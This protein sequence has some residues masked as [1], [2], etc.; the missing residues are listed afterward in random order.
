MP[1]FLAF[2]T[3]SDNTIEAETVVTQEDIAEKILL[4]NFGLACPLNT[5]EEV[6]E[7]ATAI[8]MSKLKFSDSTGEGMSHGVSEE[9]STATQESSDI[10]GQD[11]PVKLPLF[12]QEFVKT[13]VPVLRALHMEEDRQYAV[14]DGKIIFSG[15][16]E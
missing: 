7:R 11:V 1:E 9:R 2:M 15:F 5:Y 12:L 10:T 13:Q 4:L 6:V 3:N 16:S 8:L 14:S